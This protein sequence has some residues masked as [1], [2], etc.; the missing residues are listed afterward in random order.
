M[1]HI[2][3]ILIHIF[4]VG[5]VN[6]YINVSAALCCENYDYEAAGLVAN[7]GTPT[8]DKTKSIFTIKD[9]NKTEI[10]SNSFFH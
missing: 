8:Y 5:K 9:I 6:C 7:C 10:L 4:L 2:F 3:L 1:F